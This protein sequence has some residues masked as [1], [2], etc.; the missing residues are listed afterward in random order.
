MR[1]SPPEQS[2]QRPLGGLF[3]ALLVIAGTG[4]LPFALTIHKSGGIGRDEVVGPDFFPVAY[5]IMLVV[6]GLVLA[7][8]ERNWRGLSAP[9]RVSPRH[10]AS[11]TVLVLLFA[12]GIAMIYVGYLLPTFVLLMG[13]LVVAYGW[14][15]PLPVIVTAMLVTLAALLLF[16]RGLSVSLPR[17][18]SPAY[19]INRRL[20]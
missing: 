15:R 16:D 14:R 20:F 19:E 18:E 10:L 11:A 8:G 1:D 9:V 6:L 3:G 7:V 4:L 5:A 12:H 2:S 13:I 17:G